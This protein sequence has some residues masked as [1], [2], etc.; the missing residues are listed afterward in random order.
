MA[1]EEF[2]LN[3]QNI[4]T[5]K[6]PEDLKVMVIMDLCHEDLREHL[7]HNTRKFGYKDVREEITIALSARGMHSTRM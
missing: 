1:V 7:E 5:E 3:F 4:A 2:I 6:L